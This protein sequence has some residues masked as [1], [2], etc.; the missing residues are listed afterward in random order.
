M[1]G[2][3]KSL[4]ALALIQG[5]NA[6][7]PLIILPLLFKR[8]GASQFSTFVSLESFYILISTF[9]LYSFEISG[10]KKILRSISEKRRS[11][12]YWGIFYSR[13]ILWIISLIGVPVFNILFDIDL[14]LLIVWSFYPL[15]IMLHGM[16]FHVALNDNEF[17]AFC[18]AV[19]RVFFA[20][21]IFILV[22][23][24]ENFLKAS[25]FFVSSYVCSGVL[26][27]SRDLLKLGQYH[28][29]PSFLAIKNILFND[30]NIFFGSISVVLFRGSN[31]L[32]LNLLSLSEASIAVYAL[33]E[34]YIKM[35]QATMV[36][37][38]QFFYAKFAAG[39]NTG[40]N[41]NGYIWKIWKNTRIQFLIIL[42]VIFLVF[43]VAFYDIKYFHKLSESFWKCVLIML[44]ATL[45]G[46]LN[47]MFG[48]VGLNFL[49]EDK[50][51]AKVIFLT[52]L[53]S[54]I[55]SV[56]TSFY[57]GEYGASVGF[58][59]SEIIISCMI[60]NKYLNK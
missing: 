4:I 8:M 22:K 2:K 24:G 23:D 45:F 43:I 34:K 36:P 1:I 5:A 35:L 19:S 56:V 6:I 31:I 51:L 30:R 48:V 44:P 28:A 16:F 25:I 10:V 60:F 58:L 20:I 13:L 46:I 14:N 41:S 54:I 26:I 17:P 21:L 11:L 27:F 50:Y 57:W 9:V 15:G 40:H 53:M 29:V 37:L 39:I 32:I 38:N 3:Y 59:I 47:Y 18:V 12:S 49:G 55:F 33:A 42:I 52:G 7:F